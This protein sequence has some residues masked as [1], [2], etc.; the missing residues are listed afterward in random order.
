MPWLR[1]IPIRVRKPTSAM[2]FSP[3]PPR[4]SAKA[5]RVNARGARQQQNQRHAPTAE[6]H[7]EDARHEQQ[8]RDGGHNEHERDLVELDKK[9]GVGGP[10]ARPQREGDQAPLGLL[11][12]IA[13]RPVRC[14]QNVQDA[15]AVQVTNLIG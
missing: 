10:I 1:L 15:C 2:A 13:N 5:P 3:M 11:D 4:A 8:G 6:V 7:D 14:R 12:R 9:S